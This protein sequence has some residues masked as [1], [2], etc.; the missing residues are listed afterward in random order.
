MTSKPTCGY[1]GC[2]HEQSQHKLPSPG[3]IQTYCMHCQCPAFQ[4]RVEAAPNCLLCKDKKEIIPSAGAVV[5]CPKCVKCDFGCSVSQYCVSCKIHTPRPSPVQGDAERKMRSEEER[6]RE[7]DDVPQQTECP[8]C[9]KSYTYIPGILRPSPRE[10][11]DE[12]KSANRCIGRLIKAV[13]SLAE[14]D[15]VLLTVFDYC[16]TCITPDSCSAKRGCWQDEAFGK[17]A[18]P[19]GVSEQ[20]RRD[21]LLRKPSDRAPHGCYCKPGK[22]GAPVIMGRQMTCRDPLKAKGEIRCCDNGR[23][24]DDHICQ[25]QPPAADPT[26]ERPLTENYLQSIRKMLDAESGKFSGIANDLYFEVLRLLKLVAELR[27]ERDEIN[28]EKFRA[29]N[30]LHETMQLAQAKIERLESELASAKDGSDIRA[31]L[32]AMVSEEKDAAEAALL[33]ARKQLEAKN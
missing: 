5:I 30:R 10:Q 18:Q 16:E 6:M 27:R 24:C 2:G 9:H 22:C 32:L 28:Q 11:D 12:I 4:P 31:R 26:A 7:R 13:I 15:E 25:K 8:I 17:N 21:S 14:R 33:E 20:P 23:F 1:E 3:D 29:L 19:T